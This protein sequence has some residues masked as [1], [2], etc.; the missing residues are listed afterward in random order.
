[1]WRPPHAG[2][3]LTIDYKLN[4]VYCTGGQKY[5]ANFTLSASGGDGRY[6]YYRDID[7]IGEPTSGTVEYELHWT[8]CGGAP[9]TFYVRDG[10]KHEASVKFWVEPPGCCKD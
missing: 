9:G 4:G 1:V 7:K 10:S 5:A 3:P 8:Q 2:G 6:T